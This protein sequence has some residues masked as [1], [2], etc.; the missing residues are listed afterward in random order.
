MNDD[1]RGT[2]PA[3]G[4]SPN[5]PGAPAGEPTPADP[6]AGDSR[7]G[8]AASA[9][10]GGGASGVR[11]LRSWATALLSSL[12]SGAGQWAAGRRGRA[13]SFFVPVASILAA[14]LLFALAQGRTELA[15]K[16]V[17]LPWLWT[18][19]AVNMGL[20]AIRA[21]ATIDAWRLGRTPASRTWI[22]PVG[23][24]VALLITAFPHLWVASRNLTWI[25]TLQT[26]FNP[27]ATTATTDP[28][29]YAGPEL[30]TTTVPAATTTTETL[31]IGVPTFTLPPTSLP[32]TEFLP[33]DGLTEGRYLSVL[34]AG[35][36]A[37]PERGGLR[38]D[39]MIVATFD[40]ESNRAYLFGL[41]R[42]LV[43][44]PLPAG[45]QKA[46]YDLEDTL[47]EIEFREWMWDQDK[48]CRK[49][50]QWR[51]DPPEFCPELPV[52]PEHCDCF[53]DRLNAIYTYTRN[54][55]RTWPDLPD[56]GME[57]LRQT[58]QTLMG[59][60]I[61]YYVLVD[62]AGF[63]A[64]VDALGGVDIY[65]YE[66]VHQGFSPAVEGG[67]IV[68]VD[69]DPGYQHLDGNQALAYV[70]SR[71]VVGDAG[72]VKRQRCMVRS[73]AAAADPVEIIWNFPTIA[74][75]ISENTTTNIPLEFVPEL[76]RAAAALTLDDIVTV[77]LTGS[78]YTKEHDWRNIP[79]PDVADIRWRITSV[80]EGT[81]LGS[82]E[83][84]DNECGDPDE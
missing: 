43:H 32:D 41:S 39:T 4:G 14:G 36:D 38:T 29:V 62:M 25:D 24:A 31:P 1:T 9:D 18:L 6:F 49:A 73:V 20:L 55:T 79:M 48:R 50:G 60:P 74:A 3:K 44:I 12:V 83:G 23:L 37:G 35:G 19:F 75:A 54:W 16:S 45:F 15:V 71:D 28:D 61:D 46:F 57:A 52:Q 22:G 67:P 81:S 68:R 8:D 84:E 5:D 65:V 66:S 56:P 69:V 33:L 59:I 26:V 53:P 76:V 7:R 47:W 13:L 17:Q 78:G 30:S 70:R 2:P 80:L 63:V 77:S 72:R 27:P 42:E 82:S 51:E 10:A 34:L 21:Y 58:M 64:L 40:L 11:P